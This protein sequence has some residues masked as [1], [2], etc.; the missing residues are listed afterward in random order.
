M[1][2][3]NGKRDELKDILMAS[4]V[5]DGSLQ[6]R[7]GAFLRVTAMEHLRTSDSVVGRG[8]RHEYGV[9]FPHVRN[10][11]KQYLAQ[12]SKNAVWGRDIELQAL[13]EEFGVN[14]VV[15]A[16]NGQG[17]RD[18]FVLHK[19]S[20]DAPTVHLNNITNTHWAFD[21]NTGRDGNCLYNAFAQ[22]L[23][24]LAVKE[25][26][27]IKK[28]PLRPL[29]NSLFAPLNQQQKH[30]VDAQETR[31]AQLLKEAPSSS[32]IAQQ[33]ECEKSRINK[34]PVTEQQQIADDYCFALQMAMEENISVNRLLKSCDFSEKFYSPTALL[35]PA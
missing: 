23:H 28:A 2:P 21:D 22:G 11:Y 10:A 26:P 19:F 14:V 6:R 13:A 1:Y 32:E 18:T 30:A 7:Y 33:M 4:P 20:D 15:T 25:F 17:T 5:A 16:I 31:F 9:A 29:G 12:Q 34:L 27:E 3:F 35:S 8:F 24:A